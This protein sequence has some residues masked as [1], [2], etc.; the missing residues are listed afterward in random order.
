MKY[1]IFRKIQQSLLVIIIFSFFQPALVMQVFAS[2]SKQV[3]RE[4]GKLELNIT[5]VSRRHQ[6]CVNQMLRLSF[7]VINGS[8]DYILPVAEAMV[9]VSD[10]QGNSEARVTNEAGN[11]TIEWKVRKT[12]PINLTITAKKADYIPAQPLKLRLNAIDC[13]YVL[14]ISFLEEYSI[15]EDSLVTG[16]TVTWEGLLESKPGSGD[17][18]WEEELSL[19]E[20]SSGEYKFYVGDYIKAPILFYLDPPVSG[21]YSLK[22]RGTNSGDKINLELSTNPVSYPKLLTMSVLDLGPN[23]IVVNYKPPIATSDGN[24]MFL[25]SNKLNNLTFPA[26]G[27]S[28]S[29]SSGMSCF[30]FY[31]ERTRYSLVISLAPYSKEN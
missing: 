27:G 18:P 28:I 15:I 13:Q 5:G 14:R 16:A 10:D 30:I 29:L 12:G 1:K 9:D 31:P 17:N 25:E 21:E 7:S 20:G 23:N 24:G 4:Y 22:V 2:S 3:T 11:V 26:S 8:W 19:A 6:V